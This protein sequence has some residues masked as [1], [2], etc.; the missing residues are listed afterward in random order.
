MRKS[1]SFLVACLLVTGQAFSKEIQAT[2]GTHRDNLQE[3][4]RLHRDSEQRRKRSAAARAEVQPPQ[5]SRVRDFGHIAVIEDSNGVVTRP[6]AFDLNRKTIVFRPTAPNALRY[7]FETADIVFDAAALGDRLDLSDDDSMVR[8]IGFAFPFFGTVYSEVFINSDGN[9]TFGTGDESSSARSLGRVTAGPPR[10]APLFRDLDPSRSSGG[11]RVFSD[12]T[13]FIVT[14]MEVPEYSDFL[15]APVQT[16]QVRLY[17]DG[18]IEFALQDIT[19][20]EALTGISPGML[21][22]GTDIVDFLNGA[23]Q[24]YAGTIAESFGTDLE[25][26]IVTTAQTFY[27]AHDDAYDYLVIYNSVL[28]ERGRPVQAGNNAVAYEVTIRNNRSGYGDG[29]IDVGRE[30]GSPY[31]LQSV[32]NLGPLSQYPSNPHSIV[33]ARAVSRDTPMTVLAH[34]A[35]HLFLAYASVRDPLNPGARPMLGRQGAHWA[36]TFNSEASLLEGNRIEDR[37]ATADPDSR[38]LTTKTV[39]GF[40]PLDQYLMGFRAAEEVSPT[41]LVENDGTSSVSASRAPQPGVAFGGRRRNISIQEIIQVEG[42]RTPDVTVSQRRF[43]FAFILIVPAGQDPKA[44]D[45]VKLETFR[46]EF[47]RFYSE[48]TSRRAIADASLARSLRLSVFPAAGVL[49]GRE[50]LGSVSI[51]SPATEDVTVFL[52]AP[53]GF[54]RVP[55]S[56]TIARGATTAS[57]SISGVR[58][59]VEELTAETTSG[60]ETVHVRL[61]VAAAAALSLQIVSGNLQSGVPGV[62]LDQPVIFRVTDVNN[63]PYSGVRVLGTASGGG[64]FTP[65]SAVTDE[66]GTVRFAWTPGP[67]APNLLTAYLEGTAPEKGAVA[68][69]LGRPTLTTAGIVNSASFKPG[70]APGSLASIFGSNL[71]T[72]PSAQASLPLPTR[73]GGTQVFLN[74]VPVSL[75]YVS[76]RQINFLVPSS[77]SQGTAAIRVSTPVGNS[78]ELTVSLTAVQPGVFFDSSAGIGAVLFSGTA[79]STAQRPATSQDTLEIYATGLGAVQRSTVYAGL[80]ETITRPEVFVGGVAAEVGFSGL[81]PGFIGLYQVNTKIGA[82]TPSGLQP[83]TLVMNGVRS[84]EVPVMIQ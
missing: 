24:E 84:N 43:R 12:G 54:A 39:E 36:F 71:S 44:E 69:V 28:D 13:R 31:R 5:A 3:A 15:N 64:V 80:E 45:L 9:L 75:L 1:S 73:L 58:T 82:G 48:A 11:V 74:G 23:S 19:A 70:I 25:V 38:F 59:G 41:F 79:V 77:A 40:S 18:R 47:E 65:D 78:P 10:I 46:A 34:E 68:S 33:E 6:N 2:C 4:L 60:F 76:D 16:F 67:G 7:R 32:L 61:Q 66:N 57:F 55:P 62:P 14:W 20:K 83:L 35:G 42:R 52:R 56:V 51:G 37:G 29:P 49:E 50:V 27:S 72:R 30:F 26:D 21:Q 22:G 8:S 17:P 81:A 63:L 53:G